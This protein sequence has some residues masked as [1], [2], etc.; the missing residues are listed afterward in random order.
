V[1]VEHVSARVIPAGCQTNLAAFVQLV[2]AS[3]AV[4]LKDAFESP[5][6]VSESGYLCSGEYANQTAAGSIEP[7]RQS[8][9]DHRPVLVFLLP[10]AST[11]IGVSSA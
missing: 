3:I 5:Q 9:T 6:D 2:E 7:E 8:S 1:D 10:G 4:P 11:G